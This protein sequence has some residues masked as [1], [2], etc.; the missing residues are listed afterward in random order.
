MSKSKLKDIRGLSEELGP[1]FSVRT[2]RT[3]QYKGIIP[4]LKLGHRLSLF[5][6]DKV[7]A[8]LDKYEVKAVG[9]K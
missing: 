4:Y 8:A 9:V 1:P 6:P 3:L 5:D 2:L 7:L